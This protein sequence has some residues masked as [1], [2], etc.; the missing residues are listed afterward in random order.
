MVTIAIPVDFDVVVSRIAMAIEE[1]GAESDNAVDAI[2]D[3]H[4]EMNDFLSRHGRNP[5]ETLR[6]LR[7]VPMSE[8]EDNEEEEEEAMEVD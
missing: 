8:S 2:G 6:T 7:G 1:N 4:E 3:V 5:E